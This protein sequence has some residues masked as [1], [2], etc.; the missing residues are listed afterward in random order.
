[1]RS[2]GRGRR[3]RSNQGPVPSVGFRGRRPEARNGDRPAARSSVK[4]SSAANDN[5]ID[6]TVA[7]WQRRL[8]RDLTPEN[9]REIVANVTGFF[10]TLAEWSQAEMSRSANDNV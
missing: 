9:A 6:R 10:N 1:M 3:C 8:G 4:R 5:L 2:L 7:L